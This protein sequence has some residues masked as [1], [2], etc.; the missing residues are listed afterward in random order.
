MGRKMTKDET[1]PK[2]AAKRHKMLKRKREAWCVTWQIG[3]GRASRDE[4]ARVIS[5]KGRRKIAE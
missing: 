3:V 2:V 1:N 4:G 5:W